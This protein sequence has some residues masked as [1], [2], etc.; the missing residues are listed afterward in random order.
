MKIAFDHQIFALQRYGG[1]SRYI[2]E[3]AKRIS[4]T[5]GCEANIVAPFHINE[6]L[7]NLRHS[8]RIDGYYVGNIPKIRRLVNVVNRHIGPVILRKSRP[9]I[10]HRTYFDAKLPDVKSARTVITLHDMIHERFQKVMPV[11]SDAVGKRASVLAADHV[12]CVS[13]SARRD[14]IEIFDINPEK[15]SVVHQGF[16]LMPTVDDRPFALPTREFVL[17]VGQ[18][19]G[20]KNFDG[21]LAAYAASRRLRENFDIVCFGGGA[22]SRAEKSAIAARGIRNGAIRQI[23]GSDASLR[24]FYQRAVAFV[25]PSLYEGFGIPPLE[26]MSFDCPVVCCAVASLPEVVG[27]AASFFEAGNNESLGAAIERVI[28]DS[29]LRSEL[30]Q[31]GRARLKLFSWE[32]CAKETLETYQKVLS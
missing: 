23:D 14:L 32:R 8:V 11:A 3:I 25:Y 2:C 15:T 27:Q 30:I 5:N 18:R 31:R 9:D 16:D 29:A 4:Q 1:I 26:A 28:D 21:L 10:V 17:F 24:Q 19:W 13:E 6:Y 7:R 22:F 12:I 20:Y